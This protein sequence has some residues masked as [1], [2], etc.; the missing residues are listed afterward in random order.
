M[1]KCRTAELPNGCLLQ[2]ST[3]EFSN[4]CFMVSVSVTLSVSICQHC[5]LKHVCVCERESVYVPNVCL[6]CVFVCVFVWV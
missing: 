4:G 3:S 1:Q 6:A 2:E 5:F